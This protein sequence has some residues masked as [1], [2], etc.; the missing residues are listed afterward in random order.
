[1]LLTAIGVTIFARVDAKKEVIAAVFLGCFVG[2]SL[3]EYFFGKDDLEAWYWLG[4]ALV[5]VLGYLLNYLTNA[6]GAP[7]VTGH[8]AGWFAPLSR[9]LPLDYA[10][11][12][13]VGAAARLLDRR[14]APG[15]R[16]RHP[17]D[18]PALADALRLAG[19]QD[20]RGAVGQRHLRGG[21]SNTSIG[22]PAGPV[23]TPRS[24]I[25]TARVFVRERE[26]NQGT[27]SNLGT[28]PVA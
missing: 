14:R 20:Q 6:A 2:A 21:S 13:M 12:G 24:P 18:P 1:M 28:R 10:S 4:P 16:R 26:R 23:P 7:A 11:A 19:G 5:G 27:A 15:D 8:L 17:H 22:P 3:T 25:T 9:P